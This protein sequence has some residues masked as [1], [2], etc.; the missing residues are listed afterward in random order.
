VDLLDSLWVEKY[1]PKE[2]K[3]LVLPDDYKFE[4]GKG[5]ER[6]EIGNFLFYGP[7]GS[8]KSTLAR[9]FCS[10]YGVMFNRKDNLLEVNGSAK[11]TRNIRFVDD[12]IEPFLKTPP[13]RD[14]YK[15]VFIDEADNLTEA[16]FKSL[17][18]IIEKYQTGYGRFIFTCN[19]FSKIPDPIQSRFTCYK[20]KQMP[21]EFILEYCEIILNKEGIGYDPK[22]ISFIIS[23]FYPDVRKIVNT[24]QRSSMS[25]KLKVD[26]KTISSSEKVIT[27]NIVQI[28]SSV[29]KGENHKIGKLVNSI[30]EVLTNHDMDYSGIYSGLFFM[31]KI[32]VPA[33]LVIN[34]YS[35][36]HN[37]CLEPPMHFMA[38]VFEIVTTMKAYNQASG[39]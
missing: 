20:F 30:I 12:V 10:K 11:E 2:L 32:P 21:L 26:R 5:I 27:G 14:K 17:R 19:Y 29:M 6:Q 38:M 24:I 28:I 3:D 8:G 25:G 37:G 18:G 23:N 34:K 33:K 35:N 39:K 15:I 36:T 16:A 1:R 7:P 9:I 22:D 13:A 4:F 31:D